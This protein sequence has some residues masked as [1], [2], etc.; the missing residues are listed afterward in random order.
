MAGAMIDSWQ[1]INARLEKRDKEIQRRMLA[2]PGSRRDLSTLVKA[3]ANETKVLE[4]LALAVTE[5]GLWRK[6]M[7]RKI[8]ELES[9]AD[10]LETVA[11]HA[12][13]VSVD[14]L[15]NGIF[16]LAALGMGKWEDVKPSAT[17]SPAWLFKLMR[18]YARNCRDKARAF[19][20]LLREYAPRQKRQMIDC[21]ILET[22][23]HTR[24]YHDKEIAFLL[25][26][27]YEAAGRK[28]EVTE[29]QIKKHRQRY[30][31]ARIKAY[32]RTHPVLPTPEEGTV[33][34]P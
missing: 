1:E 18:A 21:L 7:R 16:W 17:Y 9:I 6:S 32:L 3:G 22:W 31:M 29:E 20:K 4:L 33:R 24:N 23:L 28:R 8:R 2:L 5:K 15:S 19:G 10:Q 14:P 13:R 26:N 27:A 12:Q 25:T 11:R 30:V 34:T